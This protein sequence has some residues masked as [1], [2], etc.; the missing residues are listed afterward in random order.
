MRNLSV[1]LRQGQKADREAAKR[2]EAGKQKADGKTAEV[3]ME[4]DDGD[5]DLGYVEFLPVEWHE[6]VRPFNTNRA[7]C[8]SSRDSRQY[9][10]NRVFFF[11]W[12][13]ACF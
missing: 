1:E 9:H 12:L 3:E 6:L 4:T 5:D 10:P 13:L 2:A 8:Y 11:S 7:L